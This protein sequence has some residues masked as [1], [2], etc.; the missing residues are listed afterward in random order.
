MTAIHQEGALAGYRVLDLT[1]EYGWI[2]GK[3]LADLGADVIKIEPSMG[4]PGRQRGPFYL[5][6]AEAEK[7]LAWWAYNT[8]K[9]S[10]CLDLTQPQGRDLG[11]DLVR[12]ADVVIE[13]FLPGTLDAWGLGYDVLR[14]VNPRLILTSITP[15][16]QS[17][18]YRHFKG[19][20]IVCM[21]VG[22]LMHLTGESDGRPVRISL[23]QAALHAGME[24]AVAS[25]LAHHWRQRSRVGQH[26]DVSM[27]AGVAWTLM[28]ASGFVPCHV[29]PP[30]RRGPYYTWVGY[31]RRL[32]F[33]CQDGYV[34]IFLVGGFG[35]AR[36][37]TAL[38]RLMH[39]EGLAPAFMLDKDW[40]NWKAS[41]L[42]QAGQVE[43]EQIDAAVAAY[44][45]TKTKKELYEAA[46]TH[47]ILLAPV[48][49]AGELCSNEQLRAGP[50][51]FYELT[52][53]PEAD[54]CVIYG[55]YTDFIVPRFA[56]LAI[57]AA[58]DYRQRTGQGQY[59]DLAQ[60]EASL[61]FLV[62]ALLDYTVNGRIM[63]RQGKRD[64]HMAPHGAYPCQGEDR[65][66]VIAVA[67]EA[68]WQRLCQVAGHPEWHLEPRFATLAGRGCT[69]PRR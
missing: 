22:G 15:F 10:L 8:R 3:V 50:L 24:A 29:P 37:M 56:A 61:H 40:L 44:T 16:G 48:A 12:Q 54:P 17:G 57:L 35:G 43:S 20:D 68:E 55:A 41:M 63:Q 26:I 52:G 38:T 31:P 45:R 9:R 49:N 34:A 21:A 19:P 39:A 64:P 28:A 66:C 6:E 27:Q 46:L 58:L 13:S 60:S 59:I 33:P 47:R 11:C 1:I 18:P 51:G 2:C 67:S 25:L 23:P 5:D 53:W 14:A 42:G 69:M 4:D 7:S 32:N 65:W 62:P 30:R 36:S